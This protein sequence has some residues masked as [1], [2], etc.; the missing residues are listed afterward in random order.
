M[1]VASL[2]HVILR[3]F[4]RC[5]CNFTLFLTLKNSVKLQ[6][7]NWQIGLQLN[8]RITDYF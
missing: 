5:N 6:H 1:L 8:Y 7:L 2:N 4:Q 3:Y